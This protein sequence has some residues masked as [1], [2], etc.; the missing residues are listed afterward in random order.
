MRWTADTLDL[1]VNSNRISPVERVIQ[2]IRNTNVEIDSA[3]GGVPLEIAW[4][5]ISVECTDFTFESVNR[6]DFERMKDAIRTS[7]TPKGGERK[8]DTL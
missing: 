6:E 4:G 8:A 1:D 7:L 2:A 3:S 5:Q